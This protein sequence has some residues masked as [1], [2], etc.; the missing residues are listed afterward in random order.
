MLSV[1]RSWL[2]GS[3][4]V[5]TTIL[6]GCDGDESVTPSNGA[7][8]AMAGTAGSSGA[9]A[10]GSGQGANGGSTGGSSGASAGSSGSSGSGGQA[11]DPGQS[12]PAGP[13]GGDIGDTITNAPLK[14]LNDDGSE[15]DASLHDYFRPCGDDSLRLL[16]VRV[17]APW[18]GPCRVGAS[19]FHDAIEPFK[20]AGV[21]LVTILFSGADN[22]P[23]SV[24]VSSEWHEQ[25]PQLPGKIARTVDF[26]PDDLFSPLGSIPFVYIVDP[27]TMTIARAMRRPTAS[28][29]REM[30]ALDLVSVGGP[31]ISVPPDLGKT[32]DSRFTT[33][34]WELIQGM[35]TPSSTVPDPT[36]SVADNVDAASF[37]EFLFF[38]KDLA[39]GSMVACATCHDP[40]RG[41]TDNKARSVGVSE[42]ALSAPSAALVGYQRWMFWDGR[43]DTSWA[44]AVGPIE[45]PI[46]MAG[47]RLGV[48]HYVA[49]HYSAKYTALFGAL[50]DG[51]DDFGRFPESG[52]PGDA[53]YDNMT[54]NDRLALDRMYTNLGKA[55]AAY[56]RSIPFPSNRFDDYASGNYDAL[57]VDE[58]DGMFLFFVNGCPVCHWG[59]AFANDAFHNIRMPTSL[60]DGPAV[61][62]RVDGVPKLLA[63]PFRADGAFSD[64]PTANAHLNGLAASETMLGQV[65]T[66]TLRLLD[67]TAPYGH[68]GAFMSLDEVI[69]HYTLQ[70]PLPESDPRTTGKLDNAVRKFH[71][72]DNELKKL[73]AFLK[74]IGE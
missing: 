70:D 3:L 33:E 12:P 41:F 30:L 24:D 55:I 57:T 51:L 18:C 21:E 50:P 67:H 9:G 28:S 27:R 2:L 66:P 64:D 25:Y 56:E 74:A 54:E 62:G 35:A 59:P 15:S 1:R 60:M 36:N 42:G 10:G 29:V 63:S 26:A 44:Q 32:V 31:D 38:D 37:G 34:D 73:V 19:H 52:K 6:S 53:A 4:C 22:R 14:I 49:S 72:D 47:T 40:N 71:A 68:A 13:Y 45:N 39:G 23:S 20:D 8:G 65:K 7:Q 61:T 48:A 46:E 69:K 5:A 11:C 16:V 17:D 43:A 58:R